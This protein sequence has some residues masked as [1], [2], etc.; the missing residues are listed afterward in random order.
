MAIFGFDDLIILLD[1]AA[2][3]AQDISNN[4]TSD[5]SVQKNNVNEQVDGA[6]E[7][8][9]RFAFVGMQTREAITVEGPMDDTAESLYDII[10]AWSTGSEIGTER[11]LTVTWD[12]AVAADVTTYQVVLENVQKTGSRGSLSRISGNLRFTGAEA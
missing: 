8:I 7:V 6:S 4:V 3:A 2:S 9:D 10:K 5:F 12:G 1:N 11:T